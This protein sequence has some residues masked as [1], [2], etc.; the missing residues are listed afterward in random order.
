MKNSAVNGRRSAAIAAGAIVAAVLLGGCHLSYHVVPVAGSAVGVGVS[1]ATTSL[2]H[3][4]RVTFVND[5]SLTI[6]VRYWSGRRD[7]TA[8][9]GV[10]DI[11]TGEDMNITAQPGE[12]AITQVGRPWWPTSMSDGVVYACVEAEAADGS[13][14]GPMWIELEQPGP[15]KFSV[16]GDS[17]DGLELKR[18]GGGAIVALPRDQWMAGNNGP[19][20]VNDELAAK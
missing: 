9:R 16:V 6:S 2:A 17:V 1:Y 4:P 18:F 14:R 5:S 20:P 3:G 7:T 11:R 15:F 8:P 10:A 13:R 12:F 19:F